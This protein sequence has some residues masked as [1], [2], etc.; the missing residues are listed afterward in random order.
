M[1]P[2]ENCKAKGQKKKRIHW[3]RTNWSKY[4]RP[5]QGQETDEREG[6]KKK[7]KVP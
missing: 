5:I 2:T 6:M 3:G 4:D 1:L 7:T